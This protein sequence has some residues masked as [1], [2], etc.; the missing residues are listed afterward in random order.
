MIDGEQYDRVRIAIEDLLVHT[1]GQIYQSYMQMDNQLRVLKKERY[2]KGGINVTSID[3]MKDQYRELELKSEY[4][5]YC[6]K[7]I[8][9]YSGYESF[10][11]YVGDK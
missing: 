3:L 2:K 9:R 8:H 4:L 6:I 5:N 1:N 10:K 11:D 7:L